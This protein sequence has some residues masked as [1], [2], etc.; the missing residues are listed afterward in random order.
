MRRLPR[1]IRN[2]NPGNIRH[3]DELEGLAE[4]QADKYFCTFKESKYGIRAMGKVLL[5]YESGDG[6]NTVEDIINRWAPNS[7]NTQ[8]YIKHV[9]QR[10][11]VPPNQKINVDNHLEE[12]VSSMILH[13]NGYS[14]YEPEVI[15]EGCE[16][17]K[18]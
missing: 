13:E 9:S 6:L 7:A 10:L 16:L 1:G 11:G 4:K 12:F 5:E 2:H 18:S 15:C 8:A 14:P 3:G 17:A